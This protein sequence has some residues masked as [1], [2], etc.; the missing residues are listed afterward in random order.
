VAID[1]A[2]YQKRILPRLREVAHPDLESPCLIWTGARG[3]HQDS[4]GKVWYE[5]KSRRVHVVV[6]RLLTGSYPAMDLLHRCDRTLC[7]QLDHLREGS[8][9]ENA[10]DRDRMGRRIGEL[11]TFGNAPAGGVPF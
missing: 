10:G 6:W 4:Y 3:G 1:L 8:P 11:F 2:T 9:S 7:G 5:G